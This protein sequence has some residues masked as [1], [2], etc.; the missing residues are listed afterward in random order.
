MVLICATYFD[1]SSD[2][3]DVIYVSHFQKVVFIGTTIMAIYVSVFGIYAKFYCYCI[4]NFQEAS[5][6]K[7]ET[8]LEE[9]K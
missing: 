7:V 3:V 5:P 4:T 8:S 2:A 6:S 9:G 1:T